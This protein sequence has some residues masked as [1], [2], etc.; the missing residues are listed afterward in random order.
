MSS[1]DREG[2]RDRELVL[3]H[4]PSFSESGR[5]S[6]PMYASLEIALGGLNRPERRPN[7]FKLFGN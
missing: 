2:S 5:A 4:H 1:V 3:K 7:P 6:V